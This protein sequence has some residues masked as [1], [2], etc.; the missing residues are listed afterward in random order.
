MSPS[1]DYFAFAMPTHNLTQINVKKTDLLNP[2]YHVVHPMVRIC[3]LDLTTGKLWN[4]KDP[5]RVAVAPFEN[6]RYCQTT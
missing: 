2:D 4:K 6:Q 3:V 5:S 1:Q